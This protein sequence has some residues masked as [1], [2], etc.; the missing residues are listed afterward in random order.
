MKRKKG[1]T[2]KQIQEM[3]ADAEKIKKEFPNAIVIGGNAEFGICEECGSKNEE[4][5]PYGENGKNIC[6]NCGKKNEERT[7]RAMREYFK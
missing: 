1:L 2:R 6:F 5:R 7:V 3:K 4:L